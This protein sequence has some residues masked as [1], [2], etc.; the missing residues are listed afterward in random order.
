MYTFFTQLAASSWLFYIGYTPNIPTDCILHFL[1]VSS[2]SELLF[3]DFLWYGIELQFC[4]LF[5]HSSCFHFWY[6]PFL[7]LSSSVSLLLWT[8]LLNFCCGHKDRF[9]VCRILFF[10]IS[11]CSCLSF[12]ILFQCILSAIFCFSLKSVFLS[13]KYTTGLLCVY[14]PLVIMNSSMVT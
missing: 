13:L 9:C 6:V 5:S 2:H 10:R 1:P 11:H 3:P 7:L 14:S 8:S 4:M 12:M